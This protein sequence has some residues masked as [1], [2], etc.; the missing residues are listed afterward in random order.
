MSHNAKHWENRAYALLSKSLSQI[1]QELNELDWKS[2]ISNNKEKIAKH[3]SAFSNTDGGGFLVFGIDD[4]GRIMEQFEKPKIDEV[5]RKIGNIGYNSLS[6]SIT[7][8]HCILDFSGVSLLVVFI[9]ESEYKPVHLRGVNIYE[10]YKRSAGQTV[11]MSQSEVKSLLAY[12]LSISF[13]EQIAMSDVNEIAFFSCLR[14][15]DYYKL[16]E[17]KMPENLGN[18]LRDFESESFI[19]KGINDTYKITNLAGVLFAKRMTDF[20]PISRKSVRVIVY[21]GPNKLEAMKEMEGKKGYAS[22]FSGLISYIMD[23]FSINEVIV[24]SLRTVVKMYPEVAVREFVANALVHQDF[25][26]T[27]TGVM[28]EIYSDRVE[29]TNPGC[30][31]IDTNLFIGANPKSRNETLASMMR[32]F[33]I[34]EERGSGVIRAVSALEAYQLPAPKFVRG[35]DYTK[36]IMFAPKKWEN[37]DKEDKIRACYQHTCLEYITNKKTTNNSIRLRFN[38]NDKSYTIASRIIADTIDA[39]LIKPFDLSNTSRKYTA[40]V[41]YWA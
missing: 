11:L 5:V 10:S 17:K 41:P 3:L 24:N 30:P 12:S 25:A 36:V 15:E 14:Y 31:L 29:I 32:R 2:D 9:P 6:V 28:I 21:N 13:E 7:V 1:P 19:K 26:I 16:L 34:C 33:G 4:E 38:L 39:G 40:Y 22:G 37:M 18:I 27:G 23:Q 8:E 20:R 35:D